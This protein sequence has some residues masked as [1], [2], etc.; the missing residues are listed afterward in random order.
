VDSAPPPDRIAHFRILGRIGSGGM[1]VV[2]RAEDEKLGRIVAVKVLP[3]ELEHDAERKRRLFREARAAAAVSHPNIATVHEVGESEGR[4]F[5]AMELVE[6]ESLRTRIERDTMTIAEALAIAQQIASGL[7]R[8]HKAGV[9]HRDLKPDNVVIDG[10]GRAKILDFGVARLRAPEVATPAQLGAFDTV[11]KDGVVIGTPA[12]MAPEHRLGDEVTASVD[13]WAFGVTLVEMITGQRPRD[14]ADAVRLL[15]K[16]ASGML[17]MFASRCL[18]GDR[19]DR[20]PDGEALVREMAALVTGDDIAKRSAPPPRAQSDTMITLATS[21]AR[22]IGVGAIAIALAIGGAAVAVTIGVSRGS[23]RAS[24][25]SP[26]DAPLRIADIPPSATDSRAAADAYRTAMSE[27][28]KG[29]NTTASARL[30][31]ALRLDPS[32]ASASLE[33]AYIELITAQ[34]DVVVMRKSFADATNH[35]SAL[36]T[37]DDEL[38]DAIAPAITDPQDFPGAITRLEALAARR[39]RDAEVWNALGI[40]NVKTS[41]YRESIRALG[42]EAESDPTSVIG[43]RVKAQAEM[44]IGDDGAAQQT[45]EEC[46]RRVPS[47]PACRF[48]TARRLETVGECAAVDRIGREMIAYAPDSYRGYFVRADAQAALDAPRETVAELLAQYEARA[49]SATSAR[50]RALNLYLLSMWSGAFDDAARAADDLEQLAGSETASLLD[51]RARKVRALEQAGDVR[52][53]AAAAA[54]M[55]KRIDALAAIE[56]PAFD[57]T[58]H[59]V[60]AARDG[61]E[62]SDD[63]FTRHERAWEAG[64]RSRLDPASEGLLLVWVRGRALPA[65]NAVEAREAI[66]ALPGFAPLPL[67]RFRSPIEDGVVGEA[68]RLDGNLDEAAKHLLAATRFCS[69]EAHVEDH[70]RLGRVRE[71]AGDKSGACSSYERVL[72]RWGAARPRSVAAEEARAQRTKLHCAS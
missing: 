33:R 68:Y 9:V 10:E 19:N 7:A 22:R 43:L 35:R 13:V 16:G 8:A 52:E 32:F 61:K 14:A 40:M 44:E 46:L 27:L 15:P 38:R 26:L 34:S 39:P 47:S 72:T 1:G 41:R 55:L 57:S 23:R 62:I 58:M 4:F 6:G 25:S 60:R 65:R 29:E 28:A 59:L 20:L 71:L 2:Y 56:R 53:A 18:A 24:S 37:R 69:L 70:I 11:T 3:P 63:D 45:L 5:I 51:A 42:R 31:E 17:R 50:V 21:P 54:S 48:E 12:Y 30:D 66:A 36:S 64:W 49:P 67:K